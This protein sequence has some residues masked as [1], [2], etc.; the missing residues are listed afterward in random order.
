MTLSLRVISERFVLF[1][2]GFVDRVF[3]WAETIHE[4]TRTHTNR[5][6]DARVSQIDW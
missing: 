3:F 1:R 4:F 2:V 5:K 6:E